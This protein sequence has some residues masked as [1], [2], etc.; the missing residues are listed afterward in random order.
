[1]GFF[2]LS[3]IALCMAADAFSV[4]VCKGLA[5]KNLRLKHM[6]AAGLY[7]GGFQA[8]MPVLG[9][10]A[11]VNFEA[12]IKSFDHWLVFALLTIIGVNMIKESFED[13]NCTADASFAFKTMLPL[14][15]A[16]SIDALAVGI[17]FAFLNVNIWIAALVIGVVTFATSAIGVKIGNIF[18]GKHRVWA[19]RAGGTVLIGIGLKILIEH[20]FFAA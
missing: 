15:L 5:V 7:F 20:L 19:E 6:L 8:L 18:G 16:T 11:G 2:E 1:M 10:L 17:S 12:L 14:A 9:Y 13:E 4:S 3:G